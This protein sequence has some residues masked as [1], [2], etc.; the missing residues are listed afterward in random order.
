VNVKEGLVVLLRFLVTRR[1]SSEHVAESGLATVRI[2]GLG[3]DV[4]SSRISLVL[5]GS[6]HAATHL[7]PSWKKTELG[8]TVRKLAPDGNRWTP[9]IEKANH[10]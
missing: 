5:T 3:R 8:P 7:L 4:H 1:P 2:T 9:T 6:L 10:D